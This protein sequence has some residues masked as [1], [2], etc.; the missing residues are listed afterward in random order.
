MH[1]GAHESPPKIDKCTYITYVAKC[2]GTSIVP[3]TGSR[4]IMKLKPAWV[5]KGDPP[6]QK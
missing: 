3:A 2:N 6:S 5:T 4:G 1:A